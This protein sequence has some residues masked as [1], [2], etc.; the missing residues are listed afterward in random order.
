MG[1]LVFIIIWYCLFG[2]S[3]PKFYRFFHSGIHGIFSILRGCGTIIGVM[4]I[5]ALL[6]TNYTLIASGFFIGII[7]LIIS[8]A[9]KNK[10][11][12]KIYQ[13]NERNVNADDYKLPDAVKKRIKIIKDFDK[14]YELNLNEDQIQRIAEASYYSPS[15]KREIYDMTKSYHIANEWFAKG[16]NWLRAYLRAFTVMEIS[17]DFEM[18]KQIVEDT[19]KEILLDIR[20]RDYMTVDACIK[21]INKKYFTLLDEPTFMIL[22]R[23]MQKR[24][25]TVVLPSGAKKMKIED[26]DLKNLERLYDQMDV[27]KVKASSTDDYYI[28]TKEDD[29]RNMTPGF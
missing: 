26:V 20:P 15:W 22:V 13:T 14:K 27:E 5:I 24:G 10:D 18:Q 17:S 6:S 25:Y 11:K 12:K 9:N 4:F 1:I 16:N 21:A 3:S 8:G 19:F 29:E 23:F 7:L 28:H 2:K